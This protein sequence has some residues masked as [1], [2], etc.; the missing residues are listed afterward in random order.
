[1]RVRM[2]CLHSFLPV[3][4]RKAGLKANE[5]WS[6]N[7]L[8]TKRY[9]KSELLICSPILCRQTTL[10]SIAFTVPLLE[11]INFCTVLF[12]QYQKKYFIL[13]FLFIVFQVQKVKTNF[14]NL[15]RFWFFFQN[16]RLFI[17]KVFLNTFQIKI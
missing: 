9:I 7:K 14:Q 12:R 4:K 3:L 15:F 17:N 13:Q 6:K 16:T 11:L 5:R 2:I 10:F 8:T 1:M